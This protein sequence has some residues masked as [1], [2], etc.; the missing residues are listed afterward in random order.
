MVIVKALPNKKSA[1]HKAKI[2]IIS[3]FRTMG[4]TDLYKV[5]KLKCSDLLVELSLSQFRGLKFAVDISIF[6]NKFVKS[7]GP[8]RWLSGFIHLLCMFKKN[9]IKPVCVFDGPEMPIEK[10]QERAR[11]RAEGA[12][13]EEKINYGRALVKRLETEYLPNDR[14]PEDDLITEIKAIVGHRREKGPDITNYNDIYNIIAGMKSALNRQT[15]QNSPIL[16][17]YSVKAKEIVSI[18]G[19]SWFQA[20]G[21]AETLCAGLCCA[22]L[23]DGVISEDTDVLAYG[24]PYLLSKIDLQ[25][26]KVTVI[27][28]ADILATFEFTSEEFRDLCILLGCDYN[29][30]CKGFPPDGKNRKKPV[31][32]GEKGAMCMIEEYRTLEAAEIHMVDAD[33]LNYRRCREL[34]TPPSV[35]ELADIQIPYNRAVKRDELEAFMRANNVKIDADYI[36]DIWKPTEITFEGDEDVLE[37]DDGPDITEDE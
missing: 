16:K 37:D 27:S 10:A 17:E 20:P 8:D 18:M 1:Y 33:C 19:F 21:E 30:R 23:V 7:A 24:T 9:G 15:R 3:L 6:L 31:G 32:I 22:D 5:L 28:H 13:K 2:T 29:D 26:E 4:I 14:V 36:M 25:N 34:F 35:L 12:K 11:R